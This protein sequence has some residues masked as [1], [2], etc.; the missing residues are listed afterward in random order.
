M[1]FSKDGV[2][3]YVDFSKSSYESPDDG[4]EAISM[5]A[6]VLVGIPRARALFVDAL[7]ATLAKTKELLQGGQ[8]MSCPN[9]KTEMICDGTSDQGSEWHCPFCGET[10]IVKRRK[11]H[12]E[13]I[14]K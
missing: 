8:K 13:E 11:E 7:H 14:K 12:L 3:G 1:I 10:E 9:C 4:A 6:N 5:L 2:N